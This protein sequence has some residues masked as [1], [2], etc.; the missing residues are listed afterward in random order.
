M[1]NTDKPEVTDD[2]RRRA[3][4][5]LCARGHWQDPLYTTYD[6]LVLWIAQATTEARTEAEAPLKDK[7]DHLE[8]LVDKDRLR[9]EIVRLEHNAMLDRD[10]IA[11]LKAENARLRDKLEAAYGLT[12]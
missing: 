8:R 4:Q 3:R 7:I 9:G 11:E 1:T 5:F 10:R 12:P 6:R 2:D